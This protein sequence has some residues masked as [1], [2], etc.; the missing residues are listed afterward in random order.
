[1]KRIFQSIIATGVLAAGTLLAQVQPDVTY[2]RVKEFSAGKTIVLDVD[3]AID[4]SFD[5]TKQDPTVQLPANI[6][7]GDPV[8]ITERNVEGKKTVEIA[9]DSEGGAKHGDNDPVQK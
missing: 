3:N 1:M 2:A 6:K 5:L 7:V 8:K 4:K 9:L